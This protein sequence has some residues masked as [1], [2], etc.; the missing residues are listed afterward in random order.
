MSF[1]YN[2]FGA[3]AAGIG[4]L[5]VLLR[6]FLYLR[7]KRLRKSLDNVLSELDQTLLDI[8][9]AGILL[10]EIQGGLNA[11]WQRLSE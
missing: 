4:L 8:Q 11:A 2:V 10:N 7:P 1:N 9:E 6:I 3:V 5:G